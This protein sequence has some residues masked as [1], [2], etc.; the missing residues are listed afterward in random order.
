MIKMLIM[1]DIRVLDFSEGIAGSL[2]CQMMGDMGADVIKVERPQGDWGRGLGA[3]EKEGSTHFYA[4]NRNK[5]NICID[6]KK[7]GGLDVA[8]SLVR[9]ADI[10]ISN[11]RPGVMEKLGI[12]FNETKEIN[13]NI[14]YGRVSAYGYD[15]PL[16]K[17]P[18]SDTILQAFS[19]LMNR[20]G[21]VDGTPFRVGIQIVDHTAARDLLIGVMAGLIARL[22]EKS[23]NSPIDVNLYATS[24]ALQAQQWQEFLITKKVPQRMGN[25]N[26]VLAPAGLYETKG[27]NHI[28]LAI[29]REEHWHKFCEAL[30][31]EFLLNDMDLKTNMDRLK[32]REKI[33]A[34]IIPIIKKKSQ[35]YWI[36]FLN[37]RDI[38]VAPVNDLNQIYSDKELMSGIPI[39]NIPNNYYSKIYGEASK[40]SIGLPIKFNDASEVQARYGPAAKG[41]HTIEILEELNFEIEKIIELQKNEEVYIL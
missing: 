12:G 14:I 23:L 1:N 34:I 21:D 22:N 28:S 8:H 7:P 27:G 15:G 38:L 3:G 30:E 31:I 36:Q 6:V 16:S 33:E 5:R 4:L 25:K 41:E 17:L 26:S 2:A 11:Y 20:T 39:V 13:P 35:E 37:E 9:S 32:N 18:G 40:K 29:L 24:A 19:G 10:M